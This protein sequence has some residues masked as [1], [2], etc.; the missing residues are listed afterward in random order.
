MPK[1]QY[2]VTEEYVRD[3]RLQHALREILANGVD[4][5]IEIGAPLHVNHNP[6]KKVLLIKNDRTKLDI[7]ALYFGGTS[8]AGSD[9]TIG[10]Y[11]EGLKLALLVLARNGVSVKVHNDD[12]DWKATI[13]P[14]ANGVRVLTIHTRKVAIPTGAVEVEVSGV[15]FDLWSEVR[16]M[17]L[18]LL[19]PQKTLK[20]NYGTILFD[21]DRVGKY[22]VR[23]VFISAQPRAAFG[24]DFA[25]L[26]VGRDR[27]SF[28][29]AD[30]EQTIAD[31]WSEAVTRA[32]EVARPLFDAM[33]SDAQ[34]LSGFSWLSR[35]EISA[36]LV[37]LFKE[38]YG[39]D[40][41]PITG[42]SEGIL[43]EHL[44]LQGVV[45]PR[46]L[47]TCLKRAMPAVDVIQRERAR[48]VQERFAL[49]ALSDVERTN[50]VSALDLIEAV[51]VNLR[52]RCVV[53][54]FGDDKIFGLHQGTEIQIARSVLRDW[55]ET[56]MTLIHEAAHD[57]GVDGSFSHASR[58]EYLVV[59]VFNRL[60]SARPA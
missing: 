59:K 21:P 3:W 52:E 6:T 46:P 17:F 31:M 30:A 38:E 7:R 16:D 57:L 27:V 40:A 50:F 22:Y 35:P 14:D 9:R 5:E 53:V 10:Q 56:L 41:Y 42:T 2:M 33:R 29:S 39:D 18:R 4:A 20:T 49:D 26:T 47:V 51:G 25:N 55:G 28:N 11:G 48:E 34:D 12:E 37:K 36:R 43:L 44:G 23:G 60:R 1:F 13:E 45:L 8:K 15:D 24:Y 54:R 58:A 32:D 19:P